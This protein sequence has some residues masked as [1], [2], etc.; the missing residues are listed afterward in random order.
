MEIYLSELRE[1]V[2]RETGCTQETTTRIIDTYNKLII[3]R[4]CEGDIVKIAG[5][6]KFIP[7]DVP[8]RDAYVFGELTTIPAHKR[9]KFTA[10]QAL[11]D[12]VNEDYEYE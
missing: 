3:E 6:G 2:R 1:L 12:K 9:I 5:I 11:K 7:V 10:Y 8:E 4:L